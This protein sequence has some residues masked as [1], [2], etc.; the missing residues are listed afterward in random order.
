MCFQEANCTELLSHTITTQ[1]RAA[2][3][4]SAFFRDALKANAI[5]VL[6]GSETMLSN[7]ASENHKKLSFRITYVTI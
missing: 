3:G 4:V 7:T 2:R 5:V 1:P 6:D